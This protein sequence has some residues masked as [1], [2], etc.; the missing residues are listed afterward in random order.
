M[1]A[2]RHLKVVSPANEKRTVAPPSAQSRTRN[3][4]RESI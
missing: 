1:Q 3:I 4:G 2:I